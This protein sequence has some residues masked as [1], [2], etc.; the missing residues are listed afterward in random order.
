MQVQVNNIIYRVKVDLS[1]EQ[2]EIIIR[3]QICPR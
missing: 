2:A 1:G 3:D